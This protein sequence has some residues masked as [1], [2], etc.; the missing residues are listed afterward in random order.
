MFTLLFLVLI[1]QKAIII[2]EV[3]VVLMTLLMICWDICLLEAIIDRIKK[4]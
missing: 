3:I 2:P 1:T 4:S